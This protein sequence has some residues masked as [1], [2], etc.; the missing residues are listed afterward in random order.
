M[1]TSF[2]YDQFV[3]FGSDSAGLERILRGL[4]ALTAILSAIPSLLTLIVLA[5]EPI[6]EALGPV[7]GHLNLT[8]RFIRFFWFLNSFGTSYNLYSSIS[9]PSPSSTPGKKSSG[10]VGVETWLEI[11]KFTLLGLYGGLESV[12]LPDLLNV[13]QIEFFGAERT[14]ALNVEAQRFWFLALFCGIVGNLVRMLKAFAYAPVPQHGA[15]YGTGEGPEKKKDGEGEKSSEETDAS[16]KNGAGEA[17]EEKEKPDWEAERARL[18]AIVVKRREERKRWRG[19]VAV[20][21]KTL[22]RK[23]ISDSLDCLIPGVILGWIDISPGAVGVAM[24]ITTLMTS[25]DIW[26]R[27]GAVVAARRGGM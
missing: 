2:K 23:V 17:G 4:Q 21:V 5:P 13:P 25:K 9:H 18:R 19:Q 24:F 15:G 11:L 16:E 26:E 12:T 1:M 6:L 27:C 3:A 22:G 10:V 20:T 8:R 14:K 7:R